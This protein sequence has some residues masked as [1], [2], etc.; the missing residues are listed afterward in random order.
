MPVSCATN[1]LI[2]GAKCFDQCIPP[3][4]QAAVQTYLLA[5]IAG[6]TMDP[7]ELAHAARCFESCIPRGEQLAVQNFLLC[8]IVNK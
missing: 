6:G 1:D 3:G 7:R 5:V 8:Q 4:M 2:A